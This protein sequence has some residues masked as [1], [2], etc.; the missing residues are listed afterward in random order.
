MPEPES[1]DSFAL[2]LNQVDQLPI[3]MEAIDNDAENVEQNKEDNKV[4]ETD[5]ELDE[6]E[7]RSIPDEGE[8][9]DAM[10]EVKHKLEI[11]QQLFQ[12]AGSMKHKRLMFHS[13]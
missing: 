8:V 11:S 12:I 5:E 4:E 7:Q 9:R 10:T 6:L 2:E 1:E 13:K 3:N